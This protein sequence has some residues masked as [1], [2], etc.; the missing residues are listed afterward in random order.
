MPGS[1]D[2]SSYQSVICLHTNPHAVMPDDSSDIQSISIDVNIPGRRRVSQTCS[3]LC[4]IRD[5]NFQDILDRRKTS[6]WISTAATCTA[7]I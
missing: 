6:G 3:I 4:R 1:L 5:G 2:F 7:D